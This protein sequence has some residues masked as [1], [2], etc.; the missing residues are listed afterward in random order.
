MQV[1]SGIATH[2]RH[3]LLQI[4]FL[5]MHKFPMKM[6]LTAALLSLI[7][8][9]ST[10][11]GTTLNAD[12]PKKIQ[13]KPFLIQN[14]LPHLTMMVKILWDDEDLAL[15]SSQKKKLIKIRKETIYGAKS[16]AKEINPLESKIVEASFAGS[17]PKG[18][19]A[20]VIKLAKLRAKA[21]II[22]LQCIYNTR[23]ILTKEQLEIL[24]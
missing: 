13:A 24:E 3:Q 23:A 22:H 10:L 6:K 15:T 18:L 19:E 2:K 12:I 8:L 7:V 16:L 11:T 4:L 9:L 5:F 20:D 14:K 1:N 21:T 17:D